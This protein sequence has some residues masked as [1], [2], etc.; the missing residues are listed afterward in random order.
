MTTE[1]EQ[2]TTN[3][4][5]EKA[6]VWCFHD[7]KVLNIPP[8]SQSGKPLGNILTEKPLKEK[9]EKYFIRII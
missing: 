2:R 1:K 5:F 8:P 7:S 3:S 4:R 9:Y 6:G